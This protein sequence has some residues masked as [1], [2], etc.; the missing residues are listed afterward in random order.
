MKYFESL[1]IKMT[2]F[3]RNYLEK[4]APY[5][6]FVRNSLFQRWM[7]AVVLCLI[8]AL[9]MAPELNFS[10]PQ[11]RIGMIAPKNIKADFAFLV[12]D[13][14]AAEEKKIQDAENI[15]P[16][17]N[18]N[19]QI[20][21]NIQKKIVK[22]FSLAAERYNNVP[23][24]QQQ[25]DKIMDLQKEKKRLGLLSNDCKIF[26]IITRNIGLNFFSTSRAISVLFA[27]PLISKTYP[28]F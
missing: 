18:Y 25:P 1:R 2:E 15:N 10:K 23:E 28:L 4:A 16:I 27:R 12:E 21:D 9:I 11:F 26:K 14:Q 17:Y 24:K 20:A 7:I 22:A 8:L 5:F 19:S 3:F 13:P 6:G